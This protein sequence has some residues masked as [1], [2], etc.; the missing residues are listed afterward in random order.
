RD[1]PVIMISALDEVDSVVRCIQMGAEDYLPRP[2]NP[3]LLRARIGACLEKKRLR[4][5]EALH[6]ALIEREQH[7]CDELLHVILPGEIVKELKSTNVVR[8]RRYE[9]VAVLFADIVGFTPYCDCH[10]P[11]EVVPHLQRLVEC[12]EDSALRHGVQK[13]KTIG[14]AFMA[15]SGL[16]T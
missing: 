7:R 2:F 4:D 10:G 8:P 6:L 5:R 3:V 13:I 12:C 14:D 15:A 16:L 11:E 9:N 1:L